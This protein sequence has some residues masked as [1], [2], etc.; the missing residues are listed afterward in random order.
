[1]FIVHVQHTDTYTAQLRHK[2]MGDISYDDDDGR[3]E[4]S[5]KYV[6]PSVD[7]MQE[8][9]KEK[10]RSRVET[11]KKNSAPNDEVRQKQTFFRD[12]FGLNKYLMLC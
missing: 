6:Q 4:N 10:K 7:G 12:H 9:G 8:E 3:T 1:M 2:H 5:M 11:K